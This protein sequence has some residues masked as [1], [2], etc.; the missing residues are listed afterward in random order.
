MRGRLG[1]F[2]RCA[3]LKGVGIAGYLAGFG[4]IIAA[5]CSKSDI[6]LEDC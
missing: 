4:P 6:I 2:A 1:I 3:L 5:K